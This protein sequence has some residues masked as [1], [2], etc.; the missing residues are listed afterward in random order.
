MCLLCYPLVCLKIH[1]IHYIT[2]QRKYTLND[3]K[4]YHLSHLRPSGNAC[5]ERPSTPHY[6]HTLCNLDGISESISKQSKRCPDY[7]SI[8]SAY[9]P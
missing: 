8:Q 6:P 1:T 9:R 5:E 4:L 3:R 7:N 2:G